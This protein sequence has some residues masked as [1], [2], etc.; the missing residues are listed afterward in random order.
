V[1][2]PPREWLVQGGQIADHQRQEPQSTTRFDDGDTSH[3]DRAGHQIPIAYG[4]ERYA[5]EI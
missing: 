3:R 4:K 5:A 2:F 1:R